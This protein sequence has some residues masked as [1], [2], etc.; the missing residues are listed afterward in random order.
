MKDTIILHLDWK[1]FL[2]VLPD[3][4]LGQWTRA[5]MHYMETGEPP[6]SM[7]KSV[8][9]AFYA[10]FERIGRDMKKYEA[11]CAMRREA[12]R[13][14]GLRSGEA[15]SLHRDE[16]NEAKRSKRKQSPSKVKQNEH[17]PDPDPEPV[18]EPV[19]SSSSDDNRVG[20]PA[21]GTMTTTT[22]LL[23]FSTAAF[24]GSRVHISRSLSETVDAL[25]LDLTR[26]VL[27]S[28]AAAGGH[29]WAYVEAAVKKCIATG[30]TT[31]EEYE[32]RHQVETGRRV[33]RLTPS[34]DNFQIG[35]RNRP[36]RLKRE[37]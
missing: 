34:G 24:E 14:G 7:K 8:E 6:Q 26:A 5:I 17:E 27:K 29:S 10:S 31:V 25:G 19:L 22:D 12:G 11:T 32:R 21:G 18:P 33:D 20:H 37:E 15:R 28:C 4:E 13:K 2:D 1:T 3:E 9:V 23:D 35:R 30:V 36:L 16:A